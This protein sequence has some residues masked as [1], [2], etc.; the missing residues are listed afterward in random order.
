VPI[1]PTAEEKELFL[2]YIVDGD[3]RSTAA[4][5]IN[6]EFTGGLF[7]KICTP[8]SKTY[9]PEFSVCYVEAVARR[10]PLQPNRERIWGNGKREL[11]S[12]L[13]ANGYTKSSHLRPE[14]LK[15]FIELIRD[16]TPA[17]SAAHELDP[18]T[19]ITQITR[20]AAK[21]PE[22]ARK[23]REAK[24]EGYVAYQESLRAEARRQA[25]AG[26]YRALRDQMIM[27]LEEAGV[28]T[29]SKHEVSGLDGGAIKMLAE[30][31][32]AELPPEMLDELIR[33]LEERELRQIESGS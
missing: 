8:E 23:F 24:E 27:Y 14:Q 26:D 25:F 31:H 28:L 21:D 5:R 6:P 29:T 15:H 10:G 32:F 13:T 33:V 18:P 7:R 2:D 1:E 22:F 16:G 9:D 11:G 19:S 30:R 12:S 17:A 4:W 3:D 20:R